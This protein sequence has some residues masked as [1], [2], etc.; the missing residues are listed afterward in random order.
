MITLILIPQLKATK[1]QTLK[2][3]FFTVLIDMF[4]AITLFM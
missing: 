2:A 3:L 4:A 1:V